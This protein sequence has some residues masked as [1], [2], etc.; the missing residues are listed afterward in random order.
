MKT[1]RN[2]CPNCKRNMV[3]VF[4][5]ETEDIIRK[6][7]EPLNILYWCPNCGTVTLSGN[8]P[9]TGKPLNTT[10][11]TPKIMGKSLY[12]LIKKPKR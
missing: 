7:K 9:D 10:F 4:N 1:K 2:V 3:R 8:C 6:R 5:K 11:R 12:E